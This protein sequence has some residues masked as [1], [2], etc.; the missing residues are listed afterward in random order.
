LRSTGSVRTGRLLFGGV[1]LGVEIG[2]FLGVWACCTW[3]GA[4]WTA[5]VEDTPFM[6]I[7]VFVAGPILILAYQ[8]LWIWAVRSALPPLLPADQRRLRSIFEI[9]THRR[10]AP[11]EETSGTRSSGPSVAARPRQEESAREN[12]L[13]AHRGVELVHTGML[14]SVGFVFLVVS[15]FSDDPWAWGSWGLFVLSVALS[16]S[17]ISPGFHPGPGTRGTV[18]G[19][20]CV[21]SAVLLVG[22]IL[23]VEPSVMAMGATAAVFAV[24]A[25]RARRYSLLEGSNTPDNPAR[26]PRTP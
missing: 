1:L 24:M 16:S 14:Y 9:Q 7:A 5:P 22:G 12:V 13:H 11:G 3:L 8:S 26:P 23:T 15:A 6:E 10:Q 17:S 25:F 4:D 2:F 18:A 19:L 20:L 21:I